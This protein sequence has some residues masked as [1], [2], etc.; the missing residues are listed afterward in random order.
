MPPPEPPGR[1]LSSRSVWLPRLPLVCARPVAAGQADPCSGDGATIPEGRGRRGG[2]AQAGRTG[3]PVGAAATRACSWPSRARAKV[4]RSGDPAIRRSGDPAIRRN[5]NGKLNSPCQPP[6]PDIKGSRNRRPRLPHRTHDRPSR[7]KK[8]PDAGPPKRVHDPT[9]P[10]KY[11]TRNAQ[12]SPVCAFLRAIV[13][14]RRRMAAPSSAPWPPSRSTASATHQAPSFRIATPGAVG[15][16]RCCRRAWPRP[17]AQSPPGDWRA[18]ARTAAARPLPGHRGRR[19]RPG[20]G[21][22]R[23]PGPARRS[24]TPPRSAVSHVPQQHDHQII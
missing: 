6:I 5:Y 17:R 1:P 22:G 18:S 7:L 2:K 9:R 8:T 10:H 14:R 11:R 20:C 15:R 21:C 19:A 13:T 23:A 12:S 3:G 24:R 4:R 16:D